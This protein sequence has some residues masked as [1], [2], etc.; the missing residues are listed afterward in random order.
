MN[1]IGMHDSECVYIYII[2]I[3]YIMEY[4][5]TTVYIT[6]SKVLRCHANANMDEFKT[7][8]IFPIP[9]VLSAGNARRFVDQ[10]TSTHFTV[11]GVGAEPF[12]AL[13][14]FEL[15]R[16][17]GEGGRTSFG[18]AAGL[19]GLAWQTR[20]KN[21]RFEDLQMFCQVLSIESNVSKAI[22][23]S[24]PKFTTNGCYKPKYGWL[25]VALLSLLVEWDLGT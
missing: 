24:I 14:P 20:R 18:F 15:L 4:K 17:N 7:F 1:A 8:S 12:D 22:G 6:A 21:R 5:S 13:D 25:I 23:S 2:Y 16:A 9:A 11:T 19:L 3:I 10:I